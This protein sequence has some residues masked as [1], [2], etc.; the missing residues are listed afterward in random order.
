[1]N[2]IGYFLPDTSQVN[3]SWGGLATVQLD[4]Q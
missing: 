2:E 4:N 3:E 1:M